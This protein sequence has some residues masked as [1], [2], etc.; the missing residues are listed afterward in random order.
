MTD[1]ELLKQVLEALDS[2]DPTIQLR[3]AVAINA[4]LAEPEPELTVKES[5]HVSRREALR[6]ADVPLYQ[7]DMN[8]QSEAT[9]ELRRLHEEIDAL[10]AALAKPEQRCEYIRGNGTTHWCALAEAGPKE[11]NNA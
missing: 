2:D 4:A 5:L 3:A 11:K 1:R 6:L 8:W 9:T 10:R 7:R